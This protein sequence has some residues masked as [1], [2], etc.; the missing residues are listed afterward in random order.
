MT[1]N[2]HL[3]GDM[4]VGQD[5]WISRVN[6]ALGQVTT[7]ASGW[8]T[9]SLTGIAYERQLDTWAVIGWG[10]NSGLFRTFRGGGFWT[11]LQ[12]IPPSFCIVSYGS[13]HVSAVGPPRVGRVFPLTFSD[14]GSPNAGYLAAASI[15][16]F[17]GIPTPIG[18]I[19]LRPDPLMVLSLSAPWMFRGFVGQLNALGSANASIVIPNAAWL[20]GM[21]FYVSFV[22]T[23]GGRL[24]SIANTKGFTII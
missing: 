11:I 19:D 6:P 8:Q 24:L 18:T 10:G 4:L 16:P 9:S 21:R 1:G 2:G 17:P 7:L 5:S 3:T 13:R 14:P 23:A 12:P 20:Q 15:F 22:T